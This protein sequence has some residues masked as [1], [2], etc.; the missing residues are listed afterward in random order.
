[1]PYLQITSSCVGTPRFMKHIIIQKLSRGALPTQTWYRL[2]NRNLPM[3][4]IMILYREWWNP[5]WILIWRIN[6][7][8]INTKICN[9]S[10]LYSLPTFL[11]LTPLYL[12]MVYELLCGLLWLFIQIGTWFHAPTSNNRIIFGRIGIMKRSAM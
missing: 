8:T 11:H 4:M 1:M 3:N 6:E 2:G 10:V 9:D 5:Y 7:T 12:V